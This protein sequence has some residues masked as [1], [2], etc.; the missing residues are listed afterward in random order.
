[1]SRRSD[2][3]AARAGADRRQPQD[4]GAA[5]GDDAGASAPTRQPA[6]RSA[7]VI[8][9]ADPNTVYVPAY[10]PSYVYGNWPYPDY[11]P[12]YFPPP[13]VLWLSA[14]VGRAV[15]LFGSGIGRGL[16]L[17]RRLGVGRRLGRRMGLGRLGRLARRQQLHDRQQQRHP[18]QQ[19]LLSRPSNHNGRWQHDPAHRHG[20][21]IAI[22]AA[23]TNTASIIRPPASA[24][25]S[26]GRIDAIAAHQRTAGRR[27]RAAH[28]A[29]RKRRASRGES[30][31]RAIGA[32]G[33]EAM[34]TEAAPSAAPIEAGR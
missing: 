16:R 18:H 32:T 23:A 7:I 15:L 28:C 19:Q 31:H 10:N 9:P 3:A 30:R 13:A 1:M 20:V 27:P 22:P 2:P 26:A 5:E 29:T 34:R 12:T 17:L 25:R 11:P 21:P 24:R 6:R 4:D 14:L 33:T 8:E